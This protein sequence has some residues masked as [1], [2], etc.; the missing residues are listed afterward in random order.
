MDGRRRN[1][2]FVQRVEILLEIASEAIFTVW[3][4]G[5]V[6]RRIAILAPVL[7]AGVHIDGIAVPGRKL[8]LIGEGAIPFDHMRPGDLQN[9]FFRTVR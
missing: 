8:P 3:L 9:V 1:V 7:A 2:V 4:P 6:A 5:D